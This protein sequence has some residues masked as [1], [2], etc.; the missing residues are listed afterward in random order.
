MNVYNRIAVGLGIGSFVYLASLLFKA[1]VNIT[2]QSILFV[3]LISI[4]IGLTSILFDYEQLSFGL[5][6][7]LHF[8]AV[9]VFT[10]ILSCT[11][12]GIKSALDFFIS[13]LAFYTISYC[14]TR[15]KVIFTSRELNQYLTEIKEKKNKRNR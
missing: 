2:Q 4:F 11:F 15:V 6:L 7:V 13:L 5:A 14:V 3:F 1:P 8:V 10:W 9:S 12:F